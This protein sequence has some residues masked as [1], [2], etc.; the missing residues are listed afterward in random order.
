MTEPNTSTETT[1]NAWIRKFAN[2]FRG[3]GLAVRGQSSFYVHFVFAIAVVGLAAFFRVTVVE[4]CLLLLCMTTVLTA[5]AFNSALE[6]MAKAVD[7]NH[8][9]QLGGALDIASGAVLICAIGSAVVGLVILVP[10][11]LKWIGWG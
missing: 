9:P 1:S 7:R 10:H 4:W 11:A 8:N 6:W 2:A 3:V 5:E